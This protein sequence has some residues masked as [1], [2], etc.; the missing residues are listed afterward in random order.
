MQG[1]VGD[2]TMALVSRCSVGVRA[3]DENFINAHAPHLPTN[4]SIKVD[5]VVLATHENLPC[6]QIGDAQPHH[7]K[8][9]GLWAM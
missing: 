3:K 7:F 4:G 5:I 6:L 1:M 2:D 9:L 8:L